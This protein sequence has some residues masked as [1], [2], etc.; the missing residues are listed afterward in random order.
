MEIRMIEERDNEQVEQVIRTCLLE[1]GLN[2]PGCAWEDKDLG[3]FSR[4][5]APEGKRYWVVEDG[6]K[7]VGGCGIGPVAGYEGVCELQKMYCLKSARGTGVSGQLLKL[8]LD[9]AKTY[10]RV[11]YLETFHIME[12]AN[13]FYQKH[14]FEQI[15]APLA[16]G[17]HY[18]CDRWYRKEL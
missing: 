13:R 10:Y 1:F 7:I 5:Y 2:K 3:E 12:A 14:G 18:A 9:F 16:G 15:E 8:A 4:V 17:A 11:C 6:G